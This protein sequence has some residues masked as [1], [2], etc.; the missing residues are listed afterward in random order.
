VGVGGNAQLGRVRA[1]GLQ[2]VNLLEEG[3]KVHHAAVAD[4]RHR[5]RAQDAGR[6]ELELILLTAY[7][8]GVPG[9]VA[10]VRLDDVINTATEK[11]G[12][13]AFSF[14][15]PLGSYDHDCW[16]GILPHS[17]GPHSFSTEVADR[18]QRRS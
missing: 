13:L 14:V 7:D 12:C 8:D 15:A 2:A 3:L 18:V 11:I 5:V 4:D 9:V 17:F 10:A 16:H 6:K 1:A